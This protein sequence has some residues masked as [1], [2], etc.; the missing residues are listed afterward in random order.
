MIRNARQGLLL[1]LGIG[2]TYL[3]SSRLYFRIDLTADGRHS[4]HAATKALL[5]E[6]QDEVHLDI[7]LTGDL[8]TELKQLKR[9]TQDL[10]KE[11]NA[12]A[13]YPLHYQFV[14]L[15]QVPAEQRKSQATKL[16]QHGIPPT[17]LRLKTQGQRTEKQIFPGTI[18]TYQGRQAGTLLLKGHSMTSPAHMV[19][20]SIEGLEYQLAS[21]LEKLVHTARPQVALLRGH[22]EPDLV[23]LHGLTQALATHYTVHTPTL[24]P[25]ARLNDYDAILIT[26]PTKPFAEAEK[27]Q[28]D[29]Y[30]M[31]GGK[32]LLFLDRLNIRLEH[33]HQQQTFALPLDLGLEDQLFRYGIRIN[34]DLVQD[35]QAG[36]Y[37]IVTGRLGN[38]PHVQLLPW[39]F[40]PLLSHFADHII[41]KNMDIIAPQFVNSIDPIRTPGITHTPLVF[42]SQYARRLGI[43]VH[44]DLEQLRQR[45]QRDHYNEKHLPLVYLITGKFTSLYKNRYP[46]E[47]TDATHFRPESP[48]TKLLVASSGSLVRNSLHPKRKQPMPWGYD[49]FLQR[50][51][52]NPDLVLNALAYMLNDQGLL[53]LKN[54]TLKIR[55][56]DQVKI[57]E[58]RLTYQLINLTIPLLLLALLALLWHHWARK[59]YRQSS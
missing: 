49:P 12:H 27:Y 38:Q 53:H 57:T 11:L 17:H 33:L 58:N 1:L 26:Q 7:Y 29:Q 25:N 59:T 15:S 35:L 41:T 4:L 32:L 37:P 3:L 16:L 10:I 46:P 21:T 18:L 47:G 30:L 34:P 22:G 19:N 13:P 9:A 50:Q 36:A 44:V 28:L 51:F 8:P 43:P 5:Q 20:Q 48:P 54:K 31:Q 24:H 2:L 45:P 39:P 42:T 56:L 6:L 14:D 55:L 23:H 40:F 52:A